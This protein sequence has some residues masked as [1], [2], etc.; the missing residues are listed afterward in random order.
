MNCLDCNPA[1]A[2]WPDDAIY[3]TGD[4]IT[5]LGIKKGMS[6]KTI[7]TI[8]AKAIAAAVS[9]SE[10]V[11]EIEAENI[12]ADAPP[13]FLSSEFTSCWDKIGVRKGR[14]SVINQGGDSYVFSYDFQDSIANIGASSMT[15]KKIEVNI[16]VTENGQLKPYTKTAKASNAFNIS[17]SSFPV[18]ASLKV[19]LES[20]ECGEVRLD[21][22]ISVGGLPISDKQF[23]FDIVGTN[24]E[25]VQSRY[26]QAD[27]NDMILAKLNNVR[28]YVDDLISGDY[29][30][31]VNQLK[32]QS[33]A[34]QATL[35]EDVYYTIGSGINA[36][37]LK[38]EEFLQEIYSMVSSLADKIAAI[39]ASR[40]AAGL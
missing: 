17:K 21:K 32:A 40:K 9:T 8:F 11:V 2:P 22:S 10:N 20:E 26:T 7:N 16:T 1:Y 31:T 12:I 23:A 15:V 29:V 36:K 18:N 35:D 33:E 3:F 4:D 25:R 37:R 6:L 14:Y 28:N 30:N 39:E 27:L 5:E 24:G 38:P 19:T 13:L 34:I